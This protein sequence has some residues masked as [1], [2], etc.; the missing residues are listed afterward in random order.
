MYKI[1]AGSVVKSRVVAHS[2]FL[3]TL[4]ESTLKTATNHSATYYSPNHSSKNNLLP[5]K[6]RVFATFAG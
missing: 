1:L 4:N 2:S 6:R 3:E 5:L